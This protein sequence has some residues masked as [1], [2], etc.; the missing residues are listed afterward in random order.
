M[1]D[2]RDIEKLLDEESAKVEAK[3][4]QAKADDETSHGLVHRNGRDRD[5]D[6]D[7]DRSF[8]NDRDRNRDSYRGHQYSHRESNGDE[9]SSQEKDRR[10]RDGSRPRSNKDADT[11]EED[12]YR[13]GN[14]RDRY[15]NGGRPRDR[16]DYYSGGGRGGRGGRSR[17][18]RRDDRRDDRR[19]DRSREPRRDRALARRRTPTPEVTE[20]D[21]DKRTVFVQQISQRVETRH[22][23]EFF[24]R[25]GT[26]IEAQIVKDR[27]TGRSKG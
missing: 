7:R 15:P 10:P 5:R 27:V 8:R 2:A 19:R 23:R 14:S 16:G 21:R 12:R 18:P 24:Q 13:R 11:D 17:S 25:V 3:K 6:R 20:D 26:V 9:R 22:L 4:L 1:A